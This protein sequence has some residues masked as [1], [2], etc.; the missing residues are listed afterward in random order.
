MAP[1]GSAPTPN[2]FAAARPASGGLG[3]PSPFCSGFSLRAGVRLRWPRAL[4]P[5]RLSP[6]APAGSEG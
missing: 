4:G 6:S 5:S 1:L 2:P 3:P